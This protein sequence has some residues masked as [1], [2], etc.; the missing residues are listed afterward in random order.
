LTS[1]EPRISFEYR[2]TKVPGD[3]DITRAAKTARLSIAS[4][5][6]LIAMKFT[7]GIASSAVSIISEAAPALAGT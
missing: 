3:I 2:G 4:N 1:G 5:T 7:V 6:L